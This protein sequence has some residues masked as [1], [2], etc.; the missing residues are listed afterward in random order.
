MIALGST[1]GV[2]AF[3]AVTVERGGEKSCLFHPRTVGAQMSYERCSVINASTQKG[4]GAR[5]AETIIKFAAAAAAAAVS[6]RW[7]SSGAPEV[8]RLQAEYSK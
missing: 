5:A 4:G 2:T 8:C 7:A 1:Q 3:K 6:Q